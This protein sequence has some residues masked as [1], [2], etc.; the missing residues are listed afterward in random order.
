MTMNFML[1]QRIFLLNTSTKSCELARE[2]LLSGIQGVNGVN[3]KLRK[4]HFFD[5]FPPI[6]ITDQPTDRV[7]IRARIRVWD[8]ARG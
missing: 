1:S 3:K 6:F 2:C 7:K 5:T 4:K 8:P